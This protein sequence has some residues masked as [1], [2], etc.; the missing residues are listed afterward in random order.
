MYESPRI[1]SV[2]G[3][4]IVI[5]HLDLPSQPVTYLATS[6]AAAGVTLTVLNNAGFADTNLFLVGKLGT[7]KTEIKKINAAV[8]AGTSLTTTAVTFAHAIG[9]EVRKVSFNQWKI[10]GNSTDTTVGATLIA[11]VDM[12]VDAPNTTYINT[13]TE[14]AYYFVVPFDSFN[15]VTGDYSDGVAK[16]TGY[17]SNSV[18]YIIE[19]ALISTKKVKGGVISDTW[20]I[21]EMND[22]SEFIASKL[23]RWSHLQSFNYVLGQTVR[24]EN[25]YALPSDI[26]E[27]NSIKSILGVRIGGGYELEYRDKKDWNKDLKSVLHTQ[28]RTQASVG[29]TTLEID[30]SYD[31]AES[32]SVEV[33]VSGTKYT[34]TYTGVTRSAT[35]GVLTGVPASGTGSITVITPVDS[36]VW[37]DIEEGEPIYFDVFDGNLYIYPLPDASNDNQNIYLDYYT[38]RTRVETAA[39]I[40]EPTRYLMYKHWL[41]WK[42]KAL[43][44]ASG[45]LNLTDGDFILF[46]QMLLDSVNKEVSGQRYRMRPVINKITY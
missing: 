19:S 39:D 46:S 34:I 4:N 6:V 24:G 17:L 7:E 44:N 42:L 38:S 16:A 41:C 40:V 36:E 14:Y 8:S 1:I 5:A 25:A 9:E 22:C 27:K 18:G 21:N 23:K 28:V 26:Q 43:D 11:T 45:N 15:T 35:A 32:G 37:Y 30:N 3:R 10:Y 31:F 33:F 2:S 29:D 20:L 13:G 12:A